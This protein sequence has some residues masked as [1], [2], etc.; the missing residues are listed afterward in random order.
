MNA[1]KTTRNVDINTHG[2]EEREI[3]EED[4]KFFRQCRFG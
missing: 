4:G 3:G 2:M 1:G